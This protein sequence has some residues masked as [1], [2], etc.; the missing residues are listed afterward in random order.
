VISLLFTLVYL[1]SQ[2]SNFLSTP[3][4]TFPLKLYPKYLFEII[5]IHLQKLA[6]T[7]E[8]MSVSS[9]NS[10]IVYEASSIKLLFSCYAFA[11]ELIQLWLL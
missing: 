6:T 1:V 11:F 9:S 8:L 5:I 7:V 2:V 3:P 10:A 4:I